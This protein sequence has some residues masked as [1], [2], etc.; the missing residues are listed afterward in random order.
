MTQFGHVDGSTK[1]RHKLEIECW[2]CC[3]IGSSV[4]DLLGLSMVEIYGSKILPSYRGFPD[5]PKEKFA[6]VRPE[7]KS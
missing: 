1:M 3:S 2:C 5:H 6:V 7:R 4:A